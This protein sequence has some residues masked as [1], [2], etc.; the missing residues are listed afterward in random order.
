MAQLPLSSNSADMGNRDNDMLNNKSLF[1]LMSYAFTFRL[2][3]QSPVLHYSYKNES[4]VCSV[5]HLPCATQS[6][7]LIYFQ[8]QLTVVIFV[9]SMQ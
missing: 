2:L 6:T 1:V 8:W 4:F 7:S 5:L 3:D 9:F